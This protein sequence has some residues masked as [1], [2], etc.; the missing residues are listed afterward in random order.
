MH[1]VRLQFTRDVLVSHQ[2]CG[3]GLDFYDEIADDNGNLVIDVSILK[4]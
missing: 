1:Y 2:A 4:E 3:E